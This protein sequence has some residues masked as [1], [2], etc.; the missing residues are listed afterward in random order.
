MTDNPSF[1][2]CC[3]AQGDTHVFKVKAYVGQDIADLQ[4]LVYQEGKNGVFRD[5]DA[6]DLTLWKASTL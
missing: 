3:L 4:K 5:T 1:V 2:I 6:K